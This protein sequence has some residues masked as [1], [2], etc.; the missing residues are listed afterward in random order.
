[1][2]NFRTLFH[3]KLHG[4]LEAELRNLQDWFSSVSNALTKNRATQS[5]GKPNQNLDPW[6]TD[7]RLAGIPT[8]ITPKQ[9]L[10]SQRY[11][12]TT[13]PIMVA[14]TQATYRGSLHQELR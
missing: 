11:I 7:L 1:M 5:D 14:G 12:S 8:T 2:N 3:G 10:Y 4:L 6:V 9:I 13:T